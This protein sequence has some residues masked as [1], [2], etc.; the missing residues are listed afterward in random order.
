MRNIIFLRAAQFAYRKGLGCNDALLTMSHHLQKSID[1][2]G[3]K[4]Y[5][6]QLDFTPELNNSMDFTSRLYALR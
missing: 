2:T 3:I 1:Y 4:P 6:V 5:I